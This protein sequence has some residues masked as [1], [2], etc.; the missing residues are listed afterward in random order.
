MKEYISYYLK[1]LV[2][3]TLLFFLLLLTFQYA[4]VNEGIEIYG[5]E[6]LSDENNIFEESSLPKKFYKVLRQPSTVIIRALV[7]HKAGYEENTTRYLYI[8]QIDTSYFV[9]KVD[10]KVIGNFGFSEDRSGHVW[11]QPFLFQIPEDFKTIEFEISGVYEI[12]IDFPVKIVNASQRTKYAILHFLTVILIPLSAGLIFTLSIILYL[13]SKTAGEVKHKVY[14]SLAIASFLG[15]VWIFDLFPFPTL[16]NLHSFL[17]LRKIFTASAYVGFA[18]L[19]KGIVNQYFDKV[20]FVD[21]LMIILNLLAALSISL[22]PSNY[23][24]KILTNNI[25]LLLFANAFYLVFVAIKT[26]SPTIFG[27]VLFFV[28]TI[29]HDGAAL[30][31]SMNTKFLSHL[32]IIALFFGFS[33]II[34]T[35]Y[36]DMTVRITTTHLKSIM[37]PLTGA[38]NRGVLSEL[39]LSTEDTIVY[40]DMDKFKMINDNYGHEVGDE[41]LKLLVRTIKNNVRS[42]DCIV[43][44]GGDEFLIVLKNCPVSKAEEIFSKVQSEFTNSHELRPVFSFDASQYRGNLD[45]T[46]RNVDKLMYKMKTQ[47]SDDKI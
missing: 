27:F 15:G 20:R 41:I 5:W 30:F 1:P 7:N 47:K 14:S 11:Y 42:S 40:V 29:I 36:R 18:F 35:E 38:Y 44:M 19:I 4:L 26:Y 45:E 46:V 17:I 28:L 37:D 25:A 32:G 16:G 39:I 13:L 22:V 31:F 12:G 34:V 6:V 23:H 21:K 2:F 3:S 10:G 43:R 8:P 9:V 24:L 33:Y